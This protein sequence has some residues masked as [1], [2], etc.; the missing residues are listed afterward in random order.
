MELKGVFMLLALAA[1]LGF[2]SY[3][4]WLR[5]KLMMAAKPDHS[6]TDQIGKRIWD[7]TVV[8]FAQSKMF[9][10]PLAGLMHALIFW[11]FLVLLFRSV[12]LVGQA[13]SETWTI[14][15]FSHTLE[16]IYTMAKD[17]TEAVVLSMII[18]AY[19]RRFVIKPWRITLSWDANLVLGLIGT[20][21][22]TDFL[23]DGAKFA[24]YLA[25]SADLLTPLGQHLTNEM[26]WA[27]VG[28][29]VAKL[30]AGMGLSV[31]AL[32]VIEETMYWIHVGALFFFLNYLPYSKH[33]HVL[34][35]I[36]NVFLKN[37][38]PGHPVR[39][40]KD[41]ENQETFGASKLQEFTWKDILDIY[42][43]TECGR[44]MTN[45]P[46][47]L[48]DKTLRPKELNEAHKHH[49]PK[50]NKVVIG[51]MKE[52]ELGETL[53]DVS[54]WKAIWDCTT[55]MSCEENCPINIEYVG[56]ITEM[57]RYL[58]L[59]ESNIPKE[60]NLTMKNLENKSNPWGLPMGDRGKW[61]VEMGVPTFAENPDAEYLF[62]LG[63]AGAYDDRSI[64]VAKAV[65]QLL[66]EAGVSFA[67][68]GEEEGCCGDQARRL[69]NEYLFQMQA[70]GNIEVFKAYNIKKIITTCPHG[71]QSFKNEYP[72]FGGNYEVFHHTELLAKL[73]QEGKLKPT[74]SVQSKI[75]FHD[76]CY[77]GRYNNIYD[78]PRQLL[79]AIPGV[80]RVEMERS[81]E[82]GFCCGG[83]GGRIWMEEHD[84]K[85]INQMRVDQAMEGNPDTL[86]SA[87]PFCLMMFKDGINEKGYE[88]K[89]KARDIAEILADSIEFKPTKAAE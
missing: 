64:K 69:G 39:P 9:K 21:M 35:A 75:S 73:V 83:G 55:C 6:R 42:S 63:C 26:A 30:F 67:I 56:R 41:I 62:Y 10:E 49:A 70:Q 81:R 34:T 84:G 15:W 79:D 1:T 8:A 80:N 22:I 47:T 85:R 23:L 60:L 31:G 89:I 86:V 12:T 16:N 50:V 52:E 71:Y 54:K 38:E 77:L 13:F 14:F 51:K 17:V 19:V 37:L 28:G 61:A 24:P 18:V 2:F 66:Q 48:S 46:T 82:T 53:I 76:S 11:G 65:I 45:C 40:I 36:Q 7:M 44:C 3:S 29:A 43:C 25:P 88:D 57:R 27:P 33:M 59:M 4:V 32:A 58:M 68:L 72:Q 87:C 74:K 5:V 20:L 78:Q